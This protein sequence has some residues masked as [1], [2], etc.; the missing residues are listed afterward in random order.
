MVPVH[1]WE[2]LHETGSDIH[3]AERGINQRRF[4]DGCE[5]R[6]VR[7]KVVQHHQDAFSAAHLVQVVM[8]DRKS[9]GVGVFHPNEERGCRKTDARIGIGVTVG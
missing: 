7:K 6:R 3:R 8:D 5:D 9:H 4:V 1:Q 2:V